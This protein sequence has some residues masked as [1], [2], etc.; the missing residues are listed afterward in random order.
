[1]NTVG[2]DKISLWQLFVLITIFAVGTAVVVGAGEEA[3]QDIW[4]A[5]FIATV[6]GVGIIFSYHKLLTFAGQRNLYEILEFSMGKIIGKVLCLGYCLYFLYIASR[7]IR[8]FGELMKVTILPFTPL[9]VIAISMMVVVMYTVYLGFETLARVTEIISPYIVVILLLIGVLLFI[10]GELRMD[11]L[12]PVLGDGFGPILQALFPTLITFPYGEV[13]VFTV[14][15]TSTSNF[16]YA[17]KVG[18]IATMLAGILITYSNIIQITGLGVDLKIRTLFPL[19]TAAREIKLMDFFERVDILVVF[20]LTC[21]IFIKVSVFFYAGLKGLEYVFNIPYR[22]LI[23]PVTALIPFFA[24]INS[25]NIVEHFEE[26]LVIV[27]YILHLPL[28][29]GIPLV[30]FVILFIKKKKGKVS[31]SRPE[32]VQS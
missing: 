16:S 26:G 21:G 11:H 15:M 31:K 13:I 14:F 32:E 28:Q 4:I 2:N 25:N 18:A 19:M 17:G 27:P 5:E 22:S 30:L 12:L 1:M 24:V 8:D 3:K 10:S 6:I 9:E 7:N 20:I 29:F 23:I